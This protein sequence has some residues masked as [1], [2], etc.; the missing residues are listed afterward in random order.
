LW[1]CDEAYILGGE[2][3]YASLDFSYNDVPYIAFYNAHEGDLIVVYKGGM[4]GVELG[5]SCLNIDGYDGSDVG[6]FA[7]LIAPQSSSGPIRI[8]YLDK[9]LGHLKY[10]DS[11]W[12]RIV[13]DEMGTSDSPKGISMLIDDNGFPVI[14]YQYIASEFSPPALRIAR[15]YAAYDDGKYGNCGDIP[16]GYF[17]QYWRCLTLDNGGQYSEEADFASL[18]INSA[19]MV[20]IAYSEYDSY[21]DVT[22]LKFIYQT[23]FRTFLPVTTRH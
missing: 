14:A 21:Y 3:K 22:S 13:V 7:S 4:C 17:V 1:E 11:S 5:W 10:Y 2:G 19:G 15:P 6:A 20:G 18:V 9:T 8:A 16:G 23:L 12:G